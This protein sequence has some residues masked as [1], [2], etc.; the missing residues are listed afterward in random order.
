M[1]SL[2]ECF[3]IYGAIWKTEAEILSS[4]M[5]WYGFKMLYLIRELFKKTGLFSNF[6]DL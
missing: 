2:A 6:S 4:A 3:Y 1:A 5:F